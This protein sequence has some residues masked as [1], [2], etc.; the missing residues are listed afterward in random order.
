MSK[1]STLS[2]SDRDKTP[3]PS[4]WGYHF[5][6]T[7]PQ[8]RVPCVLGDMLAPLSADD[9]PP[10]TPE[11]MESVQAALTLLAHL[12]GDRD[13][14]FFLGGDSTK[15]EENR[16]KARDILLAARGLAGILRVVAAPT[17]R[18]AAAATTTATPS[19]DLGDAEQPTGALIDTDYDA[20]ILPPKL[21]ET[22]LRRAGWAEPQAR[23]ATFATFRKGMTWLDVPV[24]AEHFAY[25]TRFREL[26]AKLAKIESRPVVVILD[27]IAA[28]HDEQG[29]P[30]RRQ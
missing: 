10:I 9:I 23:S 13:L 1:V 14:I 8:R 26:L 28:P 15:L 21:V 2:L 20:L 6:H 27:D 4:G 19:T 30:L 18:P 12:V 7:D 17:G 22:Y 29:K 16:V 3:A 5:H 25:P 11:A 24:C